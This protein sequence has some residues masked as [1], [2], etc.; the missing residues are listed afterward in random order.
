MKRYLV[1]NSTGLKNRRIGIV[2]KI[3]SGGVNVTSE[4]L[5]F[6][7]RWGTTHII[8]PNDIEVHTHLDL[9]I[10]QGGADVNP[11]RYGEFPHPETGNPDLGMEF[12]DSYI[13]GGY[14]EAGVPIFGICRGFQTL[15]VHEGG[16]LVQHITKKV[17]SPRSALI[18]ELNLTESGRDL[19]MRNKRPVEVIDK[20]K[21]NT[22][23]HQG[24]YQFGIPDDFEVLAT[25]EFGNIEA[26]MSKTRP[27]A[28]VQYHPEEIFDYLSLDII[29]NLLTMKKKS[30]DIPMCSI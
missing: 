30:E 19:L 6:A 28:G 3:N 23:H 12:F 21:V 5:K 9:L 4:Y 18:E 29:N 1:K 22:L 10:L 20:Y 27:I 8:M 14:I 25:G 7:E 26:F 2:A 16:V 13:L 17:S 11:I 24:A 15:I